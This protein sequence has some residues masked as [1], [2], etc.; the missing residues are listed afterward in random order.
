MPG[1]SNEARD[2]HHRGDSGRV[3]MNI[4]T[5][6]ESMIWIKNGNRQENEL[7]KKCVP[8]VIFIVSCIISTQVHL[9]IILDMLTQRAAAKPVP[10][11]IPNP[12]TW[13]PRLC[14]FDNSACQ[15]EVVAR[16]PPTPSPRMIRETI[17]CA[18][19]KDDP[20]KTDPINW[21]VVA[22]KMVFRR[23]QRSPRKVQASAPNVPASVYRAMTVPV[24]VV[25]I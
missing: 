8:K 12:E 11:N 2:T 17:N 18:N 25:E 6:K 23:P 15:T 3:K 7:D 1:R 21:T 16:I 10:Q 20:I 13:E 5:S 4:I 9:D 22:A 24:V 14:G 19:P